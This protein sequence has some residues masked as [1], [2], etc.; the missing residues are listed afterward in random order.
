MR[1]LP[2][3]AGVSA[4]LLV[5]G[6]AA[7]PT[8]DAAAATE[9][10]TLYVVVNGAGCN[11]SGPGTQAEPF[12]TIQAAANVVD[13]GQT[14]DITGANSQGVTTPLTITR[15]G[16]SAE[17]ITFTYGA[18]G[19]LIVYPDGTS[20]P[21][22]ATVQFA[23]GKAAENT[24][25]ATGST[26]DFYNNSSGSLDLD[27][28]TYGIDDINTTEGYGASGE[29]YTPITPARVLGSTKLAAHHSVTFQVAG[30]DGIPVGATDVLLNITASAETTAG[31]FVTYAASGSPLYAV[32]SGFWAKG[33]QITNLVMMGVEGDAVIDNTSSGSA[34]FTADAVG[35]YTFGGQTSMFLPATPRRLLNVKINGRQTV[36]SRLRVVEC[37]PP[38]MRSRS[39]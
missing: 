39:T 5:I 37:R 13:P 32:D 21:S 18:S 24:T 15:S 26:V 34:N 2:G 11:D 31:G 17:P 25:L 23:G 38:P 20:R 27:V 10:S 7:V 12:C 28:L 6:L 35:Y 4:A 19:G 22:I 3:A 1:V 30:R 16:T 36:N 33:Q 14:V 9:S 29:T 8:V